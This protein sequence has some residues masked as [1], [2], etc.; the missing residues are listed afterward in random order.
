MRFVKLTILVITGAFWF[1]GGSL[2]ASGVDNIDINFDRDSKYLPFYFSEQESFNFGNDRVALGRSVQV[3]QLSDEPGID[4][5]VIIGI[6][7]RLDSGEY[8]SFLVKNIGTGEILSQDPIDI[9]FTDFVVATEPQTGTVYAVGS[10]VLGDSA[11]VVRNVPGTDIFDSLFILKG[12]DRSGDGKWTGSVHF[13]A[14]S[15]YDL[16]GRL[17]LFVF[18]T[19]G[20][21][22][23]PRRL[24]CIELDPFRIEWTREISSPIGRS[25]FYVCPDSLDPRLLFTT[26]GFQNGAVD[27]IFDDRYGY[28]VALGAGGEVK[29]VHRSLAHFG[30]SVLA[31]IDTTNHEF[32]F[33]HNQAITESQ[34][35]ATGDSSSHWI[36]IADKRGDIKRSTVVSELVR[37]IWAMPYDGSPESHI[38]VLGVSGVVSVY[39]RALELVAQSNTANL[40][41]YL[42][43]LSMA[44]HDGAVL[45][46][47]TRGGLAFYST[48]FEKLAVYERA[49]AHVRPLVI[50]AG[51]AVSLVIS[52][53]NRGSIVEVHSR[54]GWL[55]F[56]TAFHERQELVLTILIILTVG[57]VVTNVLRLRTS[58][59]LR[60][61][62]QMLSSLFDNMQDGFYRT[63]L[64]GYLTWAS[65]SCSILL[66]GG[67]DLNPV[68]MRAE[69]FYV[70]PKQR[71]VLAEEIAKHG[72]V[73]DWAVE[74]R[75]TDGQL[76]VVSTSSNYYYDKNGKVAGIEGVFRDITHRRE[77]EE[78]LKLSEEQYRSLVENVDAAISLITSDGIFEFINDTGA[79]QFGQSVESIIGQSLFDLF[80]PQFAEQRVRIIKE[81][82]RTEKEFNGEMQTYIQ[83]KWMWFQVS[84]RAYHEHKRG[85]P[86]AMVIA[87]DITERKNSEAQIRL[88]SSAVE[89][90]SEGIGVADMDGKITFVNEALAAMHGYTREEMQGQPFTKFYAPE[91]SQAIED[92][93]AQIG[94]KGW[95]SGEWSHLHK[96]GT[97]F[98]TLQ[99]NS[100][101][102]DEARNV[103]GM[104]ATMIDITESKRVEEAL[105]ESEEKYRGIFDE[106]VAT[107]YIFDNEKNFIDSNLAGLD[108]LGYSREELLWM[109]IP[110]VDA[111][112]TEVLT[113]HKQLLSGNKLYN[114]EHQLRRKDGRIITVLNNSRPLTD[115]QGAVVGMQSTL[116]DITDRKRV[117]ETLHH[118][119][120][121]E[122]LVASISTEFVTLSYDDI[123]EGINSALVKIGQFMG[124]DR[125]YLFRIQDNQKYMRITHQWHSQGTES[126]ADIAEQVPLNQIPWWSKK[127]KLLQYIALSSL[128]DLPEKAETERKYFESMGTKSVLAVPLKLHGKVI[129]SLHFSCLKTAREWPSEDIRMLN[130]IGEIFVN[131]LE[132]KHKTEELARVNRERLDQ[133]RQIAGGFAHEIRNALF[134][135]RGMLDKLVNS[136]AK[137]DRTEN[138]QVYS[139]MVDDSLTRAIDIVGSILEYTRLG[140]QKLEEKVSVVDTVN[141]VVEANRYLLEKTNL[142]LDRRGNDNVMVLCNRQQLYMVLNNLVLNAID[143]LANHPEPELKII[144]APKDGLVEIRVSDNGLGMTPEVQ[145][146]IF[147]AFYSTKPDRGTGLGLATVKKIVAL[148]DGK[149]VVQSA[150]GQGTTFWL[151]FRD[152]RTAR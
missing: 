140:S 3:F 17:E 68:G 134:P 104:V 111:A 25:T 4:P 5:I 14:Q 42:G 48:D 57:L 44:G 102:R 99:T 110:D 148:Y 50:R 133:E 64:D 135:A 19:T 129:G 9:T 35:A 144:W 98:P 62:E 78:A 91:E 37:S 152:G 29:F 45:V 28:F 66:G 46:F 24:A 89:Q 122:M 6:N 63:D 74:L 107:V 149:V 96:D 39:N 73:T 118:R 15:D 79:R 11:I 82:I 16:D 38:Y 40:S 1:G 18:I 60:A 139:K 41:A 59:R 132:Q 136:M 150:L 34:L 55:V 8:A 94:D 112:P 123:D 137:E 100:L 121:I 56:I 106:S 83:G 32:C 12:E 31:E 30:A 125:G 77:M 93:V 151:T 67:E 130:V 108:L 105:R 21:D 72:R 13:L 90:S 7:T 10:G 65:P 20:R 80:P 131:A 70:D 141:E 52:G 146:R 47:G 2:S 127:L 145:S 69:D 61:R 75:R 92:A 58:R 126:M 49:D 138:N 27:E 113:A 53:A 23:S 26:Y 147:E 97:V 117:E 76:I 81:V 115:A 142:R 119:V 84:V 71:Q 116:I 124:A 43:Q 103:I 114:F 95:F 51:K 128:S 86:M 101:L 87:H 36:S 88:L 33:Y 54:S 85:V 143:A 120:E 109:S 22:I